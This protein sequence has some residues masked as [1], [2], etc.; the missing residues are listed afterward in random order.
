M[1]SVFGDIII[2]LD[3]FKRDL[4][5]LIVDILEDNKDVIEELNISQLQQGERSDGSSLP[6]YSPRSVKV[7]HKPAGPMKLFDTGAFYRGITARINPH[8][9]EMVGEDSKTK[10]LQTSYGVGILGLSDQS[11]TELQDFILLPALKQKAV[12]YLER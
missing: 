3:N 8:T 10:K 7:F 9:V 11:I 6:D 1:V 2:K 4:P 12:N 5:A